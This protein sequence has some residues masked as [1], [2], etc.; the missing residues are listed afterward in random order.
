MYGTFY[1]TKLSQLNYEVYATSGFTNA[2][3]SGDASRINSIDGIRQARSNSTSSDNNEGKAVVGRL[4]FSPFLGVEIGGSGFRGSYDK[5][6][7]RMLNIWA[8]DWTFQRGPFEFIGESA[9][10][11]IEDNNLLQGSNQSAYARKT[12]TVTADVGLLPTSELPFPS[13]VADK[14]SPIAF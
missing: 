2:F 14:L 1:P 12:F 11:Y 9:W 3:S 7:D 10:T 4:S 6:S 8:L 5:Q 13:P